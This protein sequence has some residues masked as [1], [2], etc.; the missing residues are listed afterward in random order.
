M[1]LMKLRGQIR[2]GMFPNERVFTVE[3]SQGKTYALIVWAEDLEDVSEEEA[4]IEV[5]LLFAD[6]GLSLVKL[7]GEDIG[8]GYTV[9]IP[10]HQLQPA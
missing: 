6:N 8:S 7:R 10:T 2:A 3:D 9:S 1:E 4:T 5:R